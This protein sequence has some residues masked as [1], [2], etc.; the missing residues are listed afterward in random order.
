[1]ITKISYS[2]CYGFFMIIAC[3]SFYAFEPINEK[4]AIYDGLFVLIYIVL[5]INTTIILIIEV[6]NVYIMHL[7]NMMFILSLSSIFVIR[8][9]GVNYYIIA[10]IF[11]FISLSTIIIMCFKN[12]RDKLIIYWI[13]IIGLIIIFS[14]S[15]SFGIIYNY[16]FMHGYII[17]LI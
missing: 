2:I 5:L 12:I 11:A 17:G 13:F 4:R 16:G 3:I 14:I 7:L 6:N 10:I 1:M 8:A 9:Y 15:I